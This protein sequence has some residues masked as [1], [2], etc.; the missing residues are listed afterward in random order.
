MTDTRGILE[1][2]ILASRRRVT[3]RHHRAIPSSSAAPSSSSVSSS[4]SVL[5][6]PETF[7]F[8]TIPQD[9]DDIEEDLDLPHPSDTSVFPYFIPRDPDDNEEDL[10][11]S[12]TSTI[13]DNQQPASQS[14]GQS[15]PSS[16]SESESED[17]EPQADFDLRNI[18][19]DI[20][21]PI[22]A[23]FAMAD[24]P[25]KPP[26]F[27]GEANTLNVE[28]FLGAIELSFPSLDRQ[29]ADGPLRERARG[30]TLQSYLD[31]PAR[32]YWFSLKADVRASYTETAAALRLRFPDE[33][34][35]DGESAR[36]QAIA[37]LTNLEQG[38]LT[39]KEY[40]DKAGQLFTL[41]GGDY[42][43]I[44]A[45][46]FVGGIQDL[47]LRVLVDSQ[48]E[49]VYLFPDALK[50]FRR[51]TRIMRQRETQ[52][53]EVKENTTETMIPVYQV[54]ELIKTLNLA[55]QPSHYQ[56]IV[57]TIGY[58]ANYPPQPQPQPAT[59]MQ[60]QPATMMQSQNGPR[61]PRNEFIC[62]T[63]G[64]HGHRYF[65]CNSPNP[66]PKEEQDRLRQAHARMN[67]RRNGPE[68]AGGVEPNRPQQTA[69][70]PQPVACV[71]L[72]D[73]DLGLLQ[74][75]S[76]PG[77]MMMPAKLVE[78]LRREDNDNPDKI[79]QLRTYFN[80]LS[81]EE[82]AYLVAMTE[83]RGRTDEDD[84]ALAREAPQTRRQR[85]EDPPSMNTRS[86]TAAPQIQPTA[87]AQIPPPEQ[88]AAA[89]QG[90]PFVPNPFYEN[91]A[92]WDPEFMPPSFRPAATLPKKKR[93]GAPGAPKPRRHIRM[94]KG[95]SEWDP[96]E[97]LRSLPVTGLDF[98]SLFDW[99]PGIRILVGKALQLEGSVLSKN[100][101]QRSSNA[102]AVY[103]V[104]LTTIKGNDISA[105]VK[106]GRLKGAKNWEVVKDG[107]LQEPGIRIF[108][109]HTN[110]EVWPLGK[111][112]EAGYRI[113]KILLDG[114]AVVN[115]MPEKTARR[116]GLRLEEND[117]IVIRTATNEVR[118]I[119]FC[120]HFDITIAGV[121]AHIHAYV[122]DI[123]QS[124]SLLLG[125]RWLYQVRA[126]GDYANNSYIIY[127]AE[128]HAHTVKP[129]VGLINDSPEVMVNPDKQDDRTE[130]SDWDKQGLAMGRSK[131]QAIITRLVE[132]AVE[133]SKDW[134]DPEWQ[135]QNSV[136]EESDDELGSAEFYEDEV[137]YEDEE[138]RLGVLEE[139]DEE[140]DQDR[141]NE[142]QQ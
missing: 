3:T 44:L 14:S 123:P 111:G 115:L 116:L 130:L 95:K 96:V 132:D 106:R 88:S 92:N 117:D 72:T 128:G 109:F 30:L 79:A 122:M 129:V 43:R 19:I 102:G 114:G 94:M 74:D 9:P 27:S 97:A 49:G 124:Y 87:D 65:E 35:A 100:A 90:Q 10:P 62:F 52:K 69:R 89:P 75:T 6:D 34:E 55:P 54:A 86:R 71:E 131:L 40:A 110:G 139:E 5:Q 32:Q 57:G 78:L 107:V 47:N 51:C 133:Q 105:M 91:P 73:E 82:E 60:P 126:V 21:A 13:V 125:R 120:T 33:N 37:D 50:A 53:K 7:P 80:G 39:S 23:P 137:E 103:A 134:A 81:K 64:Q 98:G 93:T 56:P 42:S 41:L 118:S 1:D 22:A 119:R 36:D 101:P 45:S 25:F 29:F 59:M 77:T 18:P 58:P 66:L 12:D 140:K 135:N 141:G 28:D 67:P 63:C 46:K 112:K 26:R 83:K 68:M 85:M 2:T 15:D 16:E 76:P 70:L 4:S 20:P 61:R 11:L 24:I 136:N 38:V 138:D 17:S 84:D 121:T 142:H 48:F 127:D 8:S 104:D 113:G 108:N 31:G 99:S